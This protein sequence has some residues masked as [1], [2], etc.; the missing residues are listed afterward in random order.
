[1]ALLSAGHL[2]IDFCTG[3]IPALVPFFVERWGLSYTLAGLVMLASSFSSSVVQ[4]LFGLFS[5]RRGALWLLPVG[6]ALA[7]VGLGL[8]AA[9]GSYWLMLPLVVVS[10]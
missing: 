8:A 10:G 2:A 3:A 5:D 6:L 7:G 1:M 9:A 4:P